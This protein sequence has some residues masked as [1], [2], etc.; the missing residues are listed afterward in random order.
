MPAGAANVKVV[1][2]LNVSVMVDRGAVLVE[3]EVDEDGKLYEIVGAAAP[4]T[5]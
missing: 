4:S 3:G 5:V 2:V 1:A